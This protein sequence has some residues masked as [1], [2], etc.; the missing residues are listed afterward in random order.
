MCLGFVAFWLET[1]LPLIGPIVAFTGGSLIPL[2]LMPAWL[3]F[4]CDYLPFKYTVYS[5]VKVLLGKMTVEETIA[6]LGV[7]LVWIAIC[8]VALVLLWS[9]GIRRYQAYGG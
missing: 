8:A 5:P 3:R 4:V 9:R 2:D 6:G 7:Q 1:G